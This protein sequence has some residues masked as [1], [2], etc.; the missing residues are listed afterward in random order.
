MLLHYCNAGRSLRCVYS[1]W[2]WAYTH[3]LRCTLIPTWTDGYA[4][5][6]NMWDNIYPHYLS[7]C[8]H[9]CTYIMLGNIVR[10]LVLYVVYASFATVVPGHNE[11]S[12]G[13][14]LF[15]IY[16]DINNLNVYLIYVCSYS[17]FMQFYFSSS[18]FLFIYYCVQLSC[19]VVLISGQV[20]YASEPKKLRCSDEINWSR[21]GSCTEWT[22]HRMR[23]EDARVRTKCI[24]SQST[25]IRSFQKFHISD[26]S[27]LSK[28]VWW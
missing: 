19:V 10:A 12:R 8:L 26:I 13:R 16:L 9:P 11:Y 2:A 24:V 7:S 27:K 17:G 22:G 3:R 14:C 20:L 6:S 1:A 5:A 21:W 23:C 15:A 25:T 28:W 18:Y 4:N